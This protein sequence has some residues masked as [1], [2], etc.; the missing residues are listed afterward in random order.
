MLSMR[1]LQLVENNSSELC[2][3]RGGGR[4]RA[5]K[6]IMDVCMEVVDT[7]LDYFPFFKKGFKEGWDRA[8]N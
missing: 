1:G 5:F 8:M 6:E 3:I 2:S 7:I 4:F